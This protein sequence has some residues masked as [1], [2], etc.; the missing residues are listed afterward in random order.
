MTWRQA[1]RLALIVQCVVI[2]AL[3]AVCAQPAITRARHLRALMGADSPLERDH[4]ARMYW[5]G[6]G[7]A[8]EEIYAMCDSADAEVRLA[9]IAGLS[10]QEEWSPPLLLSLLADN[11]RE[12]RLAATKLIQNISTG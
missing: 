4:A 2:V 9:G 8:Q 11:D 12:V 10:L 3:I 6:L 7:T 5:Q 1:E